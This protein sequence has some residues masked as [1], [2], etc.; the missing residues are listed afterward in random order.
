MAKR[1]INCFNLKPLTNNVFIIFKTEHID[2]EYVHRF[3]AVYNVHPGLGTN[4]R[5]HTTCSKVHH[6][7]AYQR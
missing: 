6:L 5:L 3:C 4:M 1:E 2:N 7:N